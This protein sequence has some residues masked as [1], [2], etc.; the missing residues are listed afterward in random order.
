MNA[1]GQLHCFWQQ[2]AAWYWTG[3]GW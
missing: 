3:G 1:G 2:A